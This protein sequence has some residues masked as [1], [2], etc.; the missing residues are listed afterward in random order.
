[1]ITTKN[2]PIITAENLVVRGDG[3]NN[4]ISVD[5]LDI[6]PGFTAIVGPSGSGKST[7]LN[8]LA[9]LRSIS[10]G[11]VMH[12]NR[13]SEPLFEHTPKT[14]RSG[15]NAKYRSAHTGYISQTPFLDPWLT[16]SQQIFTQ[17]AVRGNVLDNSYV[18]QLIEQ[19]DLVNIFTAIKHQG[20]IGRLKK[21]EQRLSKVLSGG[22]AQRLAAVVALCH[23]PEIL[24]GDEPASALGTKHKVP[25]Y[26]TLQ[27]TVNELGK[28]VIIVSHDDSISD[29]ANNIINVEDGFITDII[30][31]TPKQSI[32]STAR[33]RA[34]IET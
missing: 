10:E 12:L 32:E 34:A 27:R 20:L 21:P 15:T 3:G 2:S 7:L 5:S 17:H 4:I 26:Q 19:L 29:Y 18:D 33:R 14:S 1:M 23:Q 16:P 28:S 9:G 30:E 24:F 8:S 31:N 11:R 6:Y 25:L 22:E 13:Q